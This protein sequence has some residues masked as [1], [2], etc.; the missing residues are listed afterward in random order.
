[1]ITSAQTRH[2]LLLL[3]LLLPEVAM[4]KPSTKTGPS[5]TARRRRG[6]WISPLIS[7][8]TCAAA[9]GEMKEAQAAAKMAE[10]A[11]LLSGGVSGTCV[12]LF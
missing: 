2:R 6:G 5:G 8:R 12:S 10:T 11:R 9:E 1:M 7:W 4:L 3:L